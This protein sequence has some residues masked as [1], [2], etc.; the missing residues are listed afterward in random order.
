MNQK[1]LDPLRIGRWKFW[2][3]RWANYTSRTT[4]VGTA[5]LVVKQ[6]DVSWWIFLTI[7]VVLSFVVMWVDAKYVVR[8][9]LSAFMEYN[10]AWQKMLKNG[11][12][13]NE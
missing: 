2:F 13:S 10:P 9:E 12:P 3:D 11:E 5:Y 6:S 1:K 8:G 4:W 7:I